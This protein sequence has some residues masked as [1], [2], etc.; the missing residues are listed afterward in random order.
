MEMFVKVIMFTA[1]WCTNCKAVK[2]MFKDNNIEYEEINADENY[3]IAEQYSVKAA[4][5]I[6]FAD[7]QT[8]KELSRKVGN[9]T[10][11]QF[12]KELNLVRLN[13]KKEEFNVDN[14][15]RRIS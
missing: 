11:Q 5:T 2:E 4:P 6:I 12:Q 14:I 10:F 9:I 3:N 13:Q 7:K 1:P 8:G 15:S